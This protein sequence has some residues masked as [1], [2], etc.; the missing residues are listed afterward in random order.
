MYFAQPESLPSSRFFQQSDK[1]LFRLL[2]G[3]YEYIQMV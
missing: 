2:G 3:D 1:I